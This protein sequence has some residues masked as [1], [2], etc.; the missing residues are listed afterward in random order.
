MNCTQ[1]ALATIDVIRQR[2]AD[3]KFWDGAWAPEDELLSIYD[4]GLEGDPP[5]SLWAEMTRTAI[6]VRIDR[7][8]LPPLEDGDLVLA[9]EG[10]AAAGLSVEQAN[11]L[12]VIARG[13]Q[14]GT[15]R[16]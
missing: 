14:A 11:Q 10:T 5:S 13:T 12:A 9:V 4:V 6:G 2:M 3:P 15:A 7:G 16:R 1:P 8:A